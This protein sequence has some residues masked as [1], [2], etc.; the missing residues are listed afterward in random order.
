MP[1]VSHGRSKHCRHPAARLLEQVPAEARGTPSCLSPPSTATS[2]ADEEARL[3]GLCA[4]AV[5]R[6]WQRKGDRAA[7]LRNVRGYAPKLHAIA[8]AI[9]AAPVKT[10]VLISQHV[11]AEIVADVLRTVGKKV[12][13]RVCTMDALDAFNDAR[14]NLRGERY[15]VLVA[16]LPLRENVRFVGV[17]SLRMVDVPLKRSELQRNVAS[18]TGLHAHVD[19]P[20]EEKTLQIDIQVAQLPKLLR[21]APGGFIY[22][23]LL[24]AKASANVVPGAALEAATELC[25]RAASQRSGGSVEKLAELQAALRKGLD[26]GKDDNGGEDLVDLIAETAL[27]QLGV[28]LSGAPAKPLR[29]ALKSLREA[30]EEEVKA[31]SQAL[32]AWKETSDERLAERLSALD[33]TIRQQLT[34]LRANAVDGTFLAA[35]ASA[36]A[37]AAAPAPEEEPEPAGRPA[38]AASAAKAKPAAKSKGKAKAKAKATGQNASSALPAFA[39]AFAAPTTREEE[40]DMLAAFEEAVD[41]GMDLD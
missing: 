6:K 26:D 2:A 21:K 29:E 32:R 7:L 18:C 19:L 40:D 24:Q 8:K 30:S 33:S 11:G 4:S 12:G 14:R 20:Q 22:R 23:C 16:E 1:A 5:Q 34:D 39:S 10:V 27:E 41:E 37:L 31:Q 28:G 17:R 15:R 35:L 38:P 25:V 9:E 36:P 13:F 3:S